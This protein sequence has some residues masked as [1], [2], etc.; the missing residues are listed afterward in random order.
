MC[1]GVEGLVLRRADGAHLLGPLD[2]NLEPGAR[3]ALVGES[4]SGKS[5]LAQA[6]SGALP[7][8]I[9]ASFRRLD[10]GNLGYLP[11]EA[12]RALHPL[13]TLG[14]HLSLLPG[15]RRQ[16]RAAPALTRLRPLLTRLDLPSDEAFLN[17]FPHALSGGQRQR[18]ALAMALSWDPPWLVLDEPTA[19]LDGPRA[20]ALVDLILD[21]H[22]ARGMGFLWI[23]HDLALARRV[24]GGVRVLYGGHLLEAGPTARVLDGPRHP[25]TARLLAAAKGETVSEW[26]FLSAPGSR[27]E[28]C[29]FA[30]RC[31]RAQTACA[32]WGSWRGE[33]GDGLRCDA[34][35]APEALGM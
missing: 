28:G 8:E 31:A 23:T 17:R 2:M 5:L 26:G 1:P 21:L 33:V 4:G 34:P 15:L 27:P 12:G 22:R 19:S 11:Q 9:R 16:E 29:P 20:K 35:L 6:L 32:S 13:L 7:Q 10:A 14:E 3:E 30:P 25:Y 18:L 24:S